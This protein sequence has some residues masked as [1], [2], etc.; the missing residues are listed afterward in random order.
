MGYIN[1]GQES[2]QLPSSRWQHLDHE[3]IEIDKGQAPSSHFS[4]L[5]KHSL[6]S[7]CCLSS[8]H[9][10]RQAY[11]FLLALTTNMSQRTVSAT[12]TQY[13]VIIS[14][15]H[16]ALTVTVPSLLFFCDADFWISSL[17]NKMSISGGHIQKVYFI[18]AVIMIASSRYKYYQRTGKFPE[19][20]IW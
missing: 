7:K 8:S 18:F 10:D 15:E 3:A 1:P 4:S 5:I 2:S 9:K 19:D 20:K 17:T 14:N 11:N 13:L 6:T 16:E 12:N